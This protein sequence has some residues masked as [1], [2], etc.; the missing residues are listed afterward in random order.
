MNTGNKPKW[1]SQTITFPQNILFIS[2]P[3]ETD[4][5]NYTNINMRFSSL[6]TQ[7]SIC[8]YTYSGLMKKYEFNLPFHKCP[9]YWWTDHQ[10]VKVKTLFPILKIL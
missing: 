10:K 8:K 6:E 7:G 4:E 2:L 3:L 1:F 9:G 5:N